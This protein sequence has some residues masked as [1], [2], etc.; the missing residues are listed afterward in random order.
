M[1]TWVSGLRR[2]PSGFRRFEVLPDFLIAAFAKNASILAATIERG[3]VWRDR[4]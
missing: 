1:S 4:E 3:I 2:Y